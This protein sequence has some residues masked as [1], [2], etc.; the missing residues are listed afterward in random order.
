MRTV[1]RKFIRGCLSTSRYSTRLLL[2]MLCLMS[3]TGFA[4]GGGRFA[5]PEQHEDPAVVIE[6]ED[7]TPC[8][9]DAGWPGGGGEVLSINLTPLAGSPDGPTG[10]GQMFIYRPNDPTQDPEIYVYF[11]VNDNTANTAPAQMDNLVLMF[12]L[13]HDHAVASTASFDESDDRGIRFSRNG[14]VERV[15]GNIT[16]PIASTALSDTDTCVSDSSA[17]WEMEARLLPEDLGLSD[18]NHLM[19]VA[20][21]ADNHPAA[22]NFSAW[23]STATAAPSTWA[24]LITRS[25][26]DFV[27]LLD[28]S[29]SMSGDKWASA[30][31]AG[32]NFRA[33]LSQFHDSELSNEFSSL[34][35]T[36]GGDRLG[37]VTFTTSETGNDRVYRSLTA[38]DATPADYT[39]NLPADPGGGT[40][41]VAGVNE[42]FYLLSGLSADDELS[43]SPQFNGAGSLDN[44]DHP[45][46]HVVR[47]KIVMLLSD[48][49]HNTP[50]T[51]M[52]FDTE[53]VDFEYLP[54]TPDCDNNT[55]VN[56]LVRIN[57]VAVGTD[58]TVDTAKLNDIK[59]CFSGSRYTNIYNIAGADEPELTA[60]LS[61]FYFE[62]IYPYYQLNEITD[63]GDDA[64]IKAG[65]RRLLFFAF[66]ADAASV[67]GLSVTRPDANVASVTPGNPANNADAGECPA[68]LGYCYLLLENPDEGTYS[69]FTANG[70]LSNGKYVLVDLRVEARFALDNQPHG[71]SSTI[72]L[73]GRLQEDGQPI[74]NADVRVDVHRPEEGFGTVASTLGLESC[75]RTG[76]SL[77]K[78]DVI[79]GAQVAGIKDSAIANVAF[80]S[81]NLAVSQQPQNGDVNP[82]PYALMAALFENCGI[83]GLKR[84]EDSGL[85]LF[86]DGTHGDATANDGL[87][88]LVFENTEIEG[89]YVFRFTA[90]GNMANGQPFQR[91][92]E[93]GEYIRVDVDPASSQTG[94]Q[95][96]GQSGSLVTSVHFVIPRD[97]HGGYLGPGH[98]DQV[99]FLVSGAQL[100]G[101][102]RD[103]SNGMYAQV[104][105]YDNSKT[106]PAVI[107]V[108]QGKPIPPSG[109]GE[110]PCPL[111]WIIW[112]LVVLLALLALVLLWLLILCRS[113]KR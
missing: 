19:G 51:T 49:K 91:V 28:Q 62:S 52:D 17:S 53:G 84:T 45:S 30:K 55:D 88:T 16:S 102:V 77:P 15:Y 29:G 73:K 111:P 35:L 66:W 63:D 81:A 69:N 48:G 103:F 79:G 27:L 86:D 75:K 23:P 46:Q 11:T 54:E 2:S 105:R 106:V 60:S 85:Q 109:Q 99:K 37:L 97:V 36:G 8:V 83:D 89:S 113:R 80:S 92:Q 20:V 108:V 107:P 90:N 98:S 78:F 6:D 96:I 100:V 41:M 32:N 101:G 82:P 12:D 110:Q 59:D 38:I 70:A 9:I 56:S 25:P 24:N 34:G 10:S 112:L 44:S 104:I 7:V 67:S 95:M 4:D 68:G 43:G 42:T 65:E 74:L 87:Y 76:P 57:T 94:S 39:G 18:I 93:L 71:T 47:Q 21:L 61:K 72:T 26:I 33:I 5:L 3:N 13:S 31:Q 1:Y 14:M 64:T 58:A 22:P 40:P 50:R